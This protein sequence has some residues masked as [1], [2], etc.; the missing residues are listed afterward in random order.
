MELVKPKF[1]SNIKVT[2][3]EIKKEAPHLQ[4]WL[5]L[6]EVFTDLT[7]YQIELMIIIEI[8][9]RQRSQILQRLIGRYVRFVKGDLYDDVRTALNEVTAD[10]VTPLLK[11]NSTF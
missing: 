5:T 7:L 3:K 6:S 9:Y 11:S 1:L 2:E 4:N 8:N 10:V